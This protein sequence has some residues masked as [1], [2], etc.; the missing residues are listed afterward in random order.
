MIRGIFIKYQL[1]I[2]K[3]KSD[4]LII[5]AGIVG[6]SIARELSRYRISVSVI[7]KNLDVTGDQTRANSG[8]VHS[9]FNATPGSLKAK[10][11]VEG[12][13]MMEG[14]CRELGVE[15]FQVGTMVAGPRENEEDIIRLKEIG[16]RN[17]LFFVAKST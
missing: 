15:Y 13:R 14:V 12:S 6:N 2:R 8:V 10:L 7:D 9:G 17:V 11:N 4:V 1:S 16:D 3:V 5:G